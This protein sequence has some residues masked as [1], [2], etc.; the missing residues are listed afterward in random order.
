MFT[1]VNSR[2]MIEL[3]DTMSLDSIREYRERVRQ[4]LALAPTRILLDC[5]TARSVTS[6]H[7]GLM[8][9]MYVDCR[10]KEIELQLVNVP[11][12]TLHILRTL[13]LDSVFFPSEAPPAPMETTVREIAIPA[14]SRQ[15]HDAIE[16]SKLSI[17]GSIKRFMHILE[18][19]GLGSIATFEIRLILYEVLMNIKLHS[20]LTRKDVVS[21]DARLD[22]SGVVLTFQDSGKP[23]DP[24]EFTEMQA[25]ETA[26]RE[27]NVRGFGL[28]MINKMVTD[29]SYVRDTNETNRLTLT[30]AWEYRK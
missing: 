15:Y 3:P 21:F 24:T 17:E 30:K 29:I 7:I 20:G 6:S 27:G 10:Q 28:T 23:F 16:L 8:W 1:D 18:E 11:E 12:Q 14:P 13:D 5:S 26:A 2:Q 19:L 4:L 22:Q 9:E 25:P